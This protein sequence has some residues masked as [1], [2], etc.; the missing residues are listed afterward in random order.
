M[1]TKSIRTNS[2][3]KKKRTNSR[4]YASVN[5]L[6]ADRSPYKL[7]Y[8]S[9]KRGDTGDCRVLAVDRNVGHWIKSEISLHF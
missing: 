7:F 9:G 1:I 6:N 8:F 2:R 5:S 4:K 3:R